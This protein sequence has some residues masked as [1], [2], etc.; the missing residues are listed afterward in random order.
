MV[1]S[2]SVRTFVPPSVRAFFSL[3]ARTSVTFHCFLLLQFSG[4]VSAVNQIAETPNQV[5]NYMVDIIKNASVN[6]Q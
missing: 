2:S 6:V 4:N 3:R 5:S 1:D